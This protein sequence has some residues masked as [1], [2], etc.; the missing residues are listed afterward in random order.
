MSENMTIREVAELLR[1]SRSQVYALAQ[2]K[3]IPHTRLGKR[4]IVNRRD[5]TE[6]VGRQTFQVPKD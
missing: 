5:L 6:W 1:L 2:R 3:E 4:I